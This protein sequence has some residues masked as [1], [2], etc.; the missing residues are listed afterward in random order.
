M[1]QTTQADEQH[2]ASWEG[3]SDRQEKEETDKNKRRPQNESAQTTTIKRF[4]IVSQSNRN[5]EI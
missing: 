1:A 2:Q 5:N 4:N 3:A